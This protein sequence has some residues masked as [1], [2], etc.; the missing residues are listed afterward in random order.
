MLAVLFV[1]V[2]AGAMVVNSERSGVGDL[3]RPRTKAEIEHGATLEAPIQFKGV[4]L[5]PTRSAE[6]TDWSDDE[7][8]IGVESHHEFRAYRLRTMQ[9]PDRHVVNDIVGGE[10]VSVTYCNLFQC[11]RAFSGDTPARPL[12]LNVAGLD[13]TKGMILGTGNDR[14]YQRTL[15]PISKD[16]SRKFPYQKTDCTVTTWKEWRA[17]HPNTRTARLGPL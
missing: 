14:Y 12:D 2:I 4:T 10:A 16:V 7:L 11:V 15:E 9:T 8:V 13:N 17:E 3:V 1:V 5:P 6:A